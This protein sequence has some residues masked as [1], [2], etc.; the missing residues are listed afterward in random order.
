[1]LLKK[2]FNQKAVCT[3]GLSGLIQALRGTVELL[4]WVC[5]SWLASPQGKPGAQGKTRGFPPEVSP[6]FSLP[7]GSGG[8]AAQGPLIRIVPEGG[9]ARVR[10]WVT[11]WPCFPPSLS[12]RPLGI[13]PHLAGA[14]DLKVQHI[15]GLWC[16]LGFSLNHQTYHLAD[17]TM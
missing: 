4:S 17:F 7:A 13:Y 10:V 15:E 6:E 3:L 5:W 12:A 1:M 8:W 16:S 2:K 11:Q 9:E 14:S